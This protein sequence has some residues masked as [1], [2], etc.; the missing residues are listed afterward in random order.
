MSKHTVTGPIALIKVNGVTIGKIRDVR[1]TETYARGEIRGLGNLEAQETPIL[2]HS[3]TFSVD[4]FLIDLKS[5]G[6][7][8]LVNREV[9]SPEQFVNTVLLNENGIDIYIYKKVP[10]TIDDTTKL[11]T[12]IDEE[13]IAILRRCFLDSVSFN[14]S[15]G[16][17]STHSQTGRFLDPIIFVQ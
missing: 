15:E 6:I 17:V 14:I 10:K 13:P 3:G 16:Q 1:A 5:S 2:S 4:A 11:V 7:K 12:A 9:V 8:Q